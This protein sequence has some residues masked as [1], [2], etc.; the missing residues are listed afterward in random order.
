MGNYYIMEV[1]KS[2]LGDED[3]NYDGDGANR[4]ENV[5]AKETRNINKAGVYLVKFFI[6]GVQRVVRVDDYIPVSKE[7]G[8]PTF[9]KTNN[10]VFWAILIEKAWAKINGSYYGILGNFPSFF[11]IHLTGAPGLH[12]DHQDAVRIE[13]KTVITDPEAVKDIWEQIDRAIH[14]KCEIY[15][16]SKSEGEL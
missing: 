2:L 12:V 15:G 9:M 6:N 1:F 8:Q 4:I 7:T 5:I 3:E 10:N 16:T 14:Q 11:S 13:D